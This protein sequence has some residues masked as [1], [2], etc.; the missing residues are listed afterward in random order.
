MTVTRNGKV[1][2]TYPGVDGHGGGGTTTPNG[3]Y[4]VL[5]KFPD[6]RHGLLDVRGAGQLGARATR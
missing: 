3:T 4:Y 6:H 1:E 5:E 2:K